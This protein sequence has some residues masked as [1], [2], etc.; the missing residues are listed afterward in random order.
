MALGTGKASKQ[1]LFNFL[2]SAIQEKYG[3]V[4]IV[5]E[6]NF[7]KSNKRDQGWKEIIFFGLTKT[8]GRCDNSFSIFYALKY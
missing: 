7:K 4:R 5:C 3:A 2:G 6:G 1:A 8:E